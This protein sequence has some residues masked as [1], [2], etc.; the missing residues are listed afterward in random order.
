MKAHIAVRP[1][2]PAARALAEERPAS[3]GPPVPAATG[4]AGVAARAAALLDRYG[5]ACV[6]A[7]G[8][9]LRVRQF[10]YGRSLWV[11]ESFLSLNIVQRS[12]GGLL[13]P[14]DWDQTAPILFLWLEKVAVT[15]LGVNEYALRAVPFLAGLALLPAV[16]ALGR[17][18]LGHRAGLLAA[19]V[20]AL[21]PPLVRY[22]NEVESYSLDALTAA[23]LALLTLRVL[24]SPGDR[25]RWLLL[26]LA[27]AAGI[28]LSTPVVFVLAGVGLTLLASASVRR[29]PGGLVHTVALGAAWCVLFGAVYFTL[30]APAASSEF[31]RQFFA[32][33]FLSPE[34]PDFVVRVG[35][36]VWRTMHPLIYLPRVPLVVR[37]MA[38]LAAAAGAVSLARRRG[39]ALL[40]LLLVPFA[41]A[42]AAAVLQ[43]YPVAQRTMLFGA[44][45][46]IVMMVAGVLAAGRLAR[47][48]RGLGAAALALGAAAL[49][50]PPAA[51]AAR[52]ALD[53]WRD[54]DART[55]VR[56]FERR[57]APDEPI[58]VTYYARPGFAFYTTDWS[59]PDTARLAWLELAKSPRAPGDR[60]LADPGDGTDPFAYSYRGR[61]E[62]AQR[63]APGLPRD[64]EGS[65]TSKEAKTRAMERDARRI[66]AQARPTA[67]VLQG[68]SDDHRRLVEALERL[69]GRVIYR[70]TSARGMYL[71]QVR[72]D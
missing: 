38:V 12:F 31:L 72:F 10:A 54:W 41:A 42:F 47:L 4:L 37:L 61:T 26:A 53:P 18:L 35:D 49:V 55:A 15:L 58:Y 5:L 63:L 8:T 6:L 50:L 2:S 17:R 34:A 27:G 19:A 56:D 39:P 23:L 66:R 14:L 24:E 30:L 36:A 57:S 11:D 29:A 59:A 43:R 64:F 48:P 40:P 13:R 51:A 1:P 32:P 52:D 44:P 70:N 7:L 33:T 45:L 68:G 20:A 25:R 46:L 16:Y 62:L 67:W 28:L 9:L 60:T 22:S 69:G 71:Y 3:D 21:S 65:R